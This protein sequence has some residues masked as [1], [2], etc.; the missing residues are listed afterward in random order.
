[1]SP[2]LQS[3][4]QPLCEL[5]KRRTAQSRQTVRVAVKKTAFLGGSHHGRT[6]ALAEPDVLIIPKTSSTTLSLPL[7]ALVLQVCM[8]ESKELLSVNQIQVEHAPRGY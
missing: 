3:E 6:E 5:V 8:I 7:S 2:L 4:A 1:M